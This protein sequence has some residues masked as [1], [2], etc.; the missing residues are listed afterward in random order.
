MVLHR[1][2]ET[3]AIFGKLT[4]TKALTQ[5]RLYSWKGSP[6]G[7]TGGVLATGDACPWRVRV[8]R[9][10]TFGA[11]SRNNCGCIWAVAVF[12]F[13]TANE[14]AKAN[15]KTIKNFSFISNPLLPSYM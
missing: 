15:N 2:V 1:P 12:G 5:K 7:T 10:R 4:S 13:A 6:C 11:R 9:T 8:S 3:A 14:G